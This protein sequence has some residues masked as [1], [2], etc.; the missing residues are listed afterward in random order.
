M[1]AKTGTWAKPVALSPAR[2]V[3]YDAQVL[4]DAGGGA[5]AVW[6]GANAL[7]NPNVIVGGC[8]RTTLEASLHPAGGRWGSPARLGGSREEPPMVAIRPRG[9]V[10]VIWREDQ[11][12]AQPLSVRTAALSHPRW[13][14]PATLPGSGDGADTREAGLA[15]GRDGASVVWWLKA[16]GSTAA[17]LAVSSAPGTRWSQPRTIARWRTPPEVSAS[18]E[19]GSLPTCSHVGEAFVGFDRRDRTIAVWQEGCGATFTALGEAHGASWSAARMLEGLPTDVS[20]AFTIGADGELVAAWLAP[21]PVT[22]VG[23]FPGKQTTTTAHAALFRRVPSQPR[24]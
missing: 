12:P 10:V 2:T 1:S 21:G 13:S 16:Q 3:I 11:A 4:V 14:A 19:T 9:E 22:A 6:S 23:P 20:A 18:P 15:S 24:R 5:A 7:P 17:L 8:S